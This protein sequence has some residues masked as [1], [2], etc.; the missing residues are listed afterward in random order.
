MALVPSGTTPFF[1]GLSLI[2]KW[3]VKHLGLLSIQQKLNPCLQCEFYT[4]VDPHWVQTF[5]RCYLVCFAVQCR[6]VAAGGAPWWVQAGVF[7]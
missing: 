6:V 4:W 1:A 7:P 5:G 3:E 2:C